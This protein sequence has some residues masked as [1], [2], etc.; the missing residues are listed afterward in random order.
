[1]VVAVLVCT[2]NLFGQG[3]L[4]LN[5]ESTT[6]TPVVFPGGTRFTATVPG[7]TW[8]PP[9]NTINADTNTVAYNEVALDSPAVTLQGTNSPF[10][11]AIQGKYS[12]LLQ[13][14]SPN[15]PSTSFSSIGQS[16][17]I[18]LNAASLVYW[19]GALQ[20]SFAGQPLTFSALSVTPNYTVWMANISA[21]AGQS[22]QLSF[23]VP[24]ETTGMLDNIQF[25]STPVPEPGSLSLA[26]T[27]LLLSLLFRRPP[28]RTSARRDASSEYTRNSEA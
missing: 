26:A 18:P 16:G 19:G 5:F 6:I 9:G 10:A 25:T 15:V 24:W 27:S 11:P 2:P 12:I 23:T 13:G 28:H 7:W 17:Q 14:G 20:G 22:G 21:Y 1:M 4:N 3:F 8:T